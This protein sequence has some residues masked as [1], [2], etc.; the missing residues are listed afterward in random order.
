M[1]KPKIYV[2]ELS[3]VETK[4]IHEAMMIPSW[5]KAVDEEYQALT[6]NGT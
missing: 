1:F 4:S 3:A 5:E 6:K 2:V